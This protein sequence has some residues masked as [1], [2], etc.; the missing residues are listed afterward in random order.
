MRT[1]RTSRFRTR[2]LVRTMTLGALALAAALVAT[3]L[4]VRG[5]STTVVISEFRVRGPN[6]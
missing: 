3:N 5:A 1:L 2:A 4:P 6:G